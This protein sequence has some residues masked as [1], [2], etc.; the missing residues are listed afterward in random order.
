VVSFGA[1]AKDLCRVG[2]SSSLT[3]VGRGGLR[4]TATGMIRPEGLSLADSEARRADASPATDHQLTR[5]ASHS[6]CDY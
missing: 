3:P 4:A 1:L 2:A 6:S 5:L